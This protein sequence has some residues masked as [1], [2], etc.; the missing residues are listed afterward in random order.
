MSWWKNCFLVAT[1][2][3]AGAL[4]YET[5]MSNDTDNDCDEDDEAEEFERDGVEILVAKVRREATLAMAQCE[6]DEEREAVYAQVKS[7]VQEIQDA[8]AKKGEAL[9]E[10]LKEEAEQQGEAADDGV[11]RHVQDIKAAMQQVRESLEDTLESLKPAAPEP[12]L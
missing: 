2:V 4:L 11:D 9:I 5:V 3:V 6:N 10:Q 12:A 1:G 8:L 7:S